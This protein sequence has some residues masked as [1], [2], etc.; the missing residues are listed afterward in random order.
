MQ[1]AA[2]EGDAFYFRDSILMTGPETDYHG[3]SLTGLT[4]LEIN[5]IVCTIGH[6]MGGDLG[7]CILVA[8]ELRDAF[9]FMD[10][11]GISGEAGWEKIIRNSYS[12]SYWAEA[13]RITDYSRYGYAYLAYQYV[14]EWGGSAVRHRLLGHAATYIDFSEDTPWWYRTLYY[15][16]VLGD[17]GYMW[18]TELYGSYINPASGLRKS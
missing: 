17:D 13:A 6:E 11:T 18:C 9:D 14:F 7:G 2:L 15:V 8:Q 12:P 10:Y 3:H 4:E 1:A 5:A 16:P